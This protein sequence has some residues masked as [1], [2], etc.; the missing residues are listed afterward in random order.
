M[1]VCVCYGC[2]ESPIFAFVSI[3]WVSKIICICIQIKVEIGVTI[4]FFFVIVFLIFYIKV[5]IYVLANELLLFLWKPKH[6][7]YN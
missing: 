3:I 4:K 1:C 7:Y 5:L 6:K 2:A